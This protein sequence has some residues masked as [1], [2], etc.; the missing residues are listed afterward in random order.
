MRLILVR[1]GETIE[2]QKGITQGHIGGMLSKRGLT[3]AKLLA[4]RL[5]D[6]K[7]DLILTSDLKRAKD[8]AKI[9]AKLHPESEFRED[10]RLR[11]RNFGVYNGKPKGSAYKNLWQ[12]KSFSYKPSKGE[13]F[14]DVIR[15]VKNFYREV[16]KNCSDKTILIVSHGGTILFLT[17]M[18]LGR[19]VERTIESAE[20]QKNTAMTDFKTNNKGLVK[21]LCLNCD[22]HL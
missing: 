6:I 8:T 9:I 12:R 3:Q 17:R 5:S 4:K 22:K 2:N 10:K 19:P 1:H 7:I 13:S 15:R 21:T 14:R 11:E 18:I 20:L 16:L